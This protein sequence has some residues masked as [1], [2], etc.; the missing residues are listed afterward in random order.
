[1]TNVRFVPK[2]PYVIS[3]GGEDK[4]IFQWKYQLDKEA[5]AESSKNSNCAVDTT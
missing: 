2:S 4:C 3:T 5:Q 1:M